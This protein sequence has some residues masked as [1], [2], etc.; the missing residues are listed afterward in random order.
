MCGR[1]IFLFVFII[2]SS[3]SANAEKPF[4]AII[5]VI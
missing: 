4:T 3:R 1:Q 5:G 2:S